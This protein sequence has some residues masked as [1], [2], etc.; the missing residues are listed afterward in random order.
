VEGHGP[1][2]MAIEIAR[3]IPQQRRRPIIG[4]F[5]ET[6]QRIERDEG[7]TEGLAAAGNHLLR[8]VI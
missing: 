8:A 5:G 6:P 2:Q 1:P 4:H 3:K 7:L